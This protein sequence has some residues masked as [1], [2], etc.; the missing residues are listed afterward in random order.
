MGKI[1]AARK[2]AFVNKF[3]AKLSSSASSFGF[4][5]VG[6]GGALK[7]PWSLL[8]EAKIKKY[9]IDPEST[10]K[11]LCISNESGEKTFHVAIDP[12]SSSLHLPN[13]E[14]IARFAMPFLNV[15][16]QMQVSCKTLDEC[17]EGVFADIMDVNT[18]GHDFQVLQGGSEI[19]AKSF[20]K[21]IKIEY[22]LSAV[23]SGQGWFSDIDKLLR[24]F[25]FELV[26]MENEY[27][28]PAIAKNLYHKGEPVWGKALY[29]PSYKLWLEKAQKSSHPKDEIYKTVLL[30]TIL[31]LPG[32]SLEILNGEFVASTLSKEEIKQ[33]R[34]AIEWVFGKAR[35]DAVSALIQKGLQFIFGSKL[36]L[37]QAGAQ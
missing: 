6:S 32:R 5:D 18:E 12:R 8:P 35:Y 14:F 16:K 31:D 1:T 21:V 10:D 26:S 20:F 19:L 3:A 13:E 37:L 9:D 34:S 25:S 33:L 30:Y 28:R 17:F 23:W 11:L 22:E 24:S 7:L 27:V 36:K 29:I 4:I 15:Q 2:A